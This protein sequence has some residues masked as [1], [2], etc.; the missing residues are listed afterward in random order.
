MAAF[1]ADP[2]N[3]RKI[4]GTAGSDFLTALVMKSSVGCVDS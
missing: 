2:L 3:K 1:H 4:E